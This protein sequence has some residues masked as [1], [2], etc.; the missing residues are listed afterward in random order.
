MNKLSNP[1]CR[2]NAWQSILGGW[3]VALFIWWTMIQILADAPGLVIDSMFVLATALCGGIAALLYRLP[4]GKFWPGFRKEIPYSFLLTIGLFAIIYF[5][6]MFSGLSDL[7]ARSRIGEN[8]CWFLTS[9]CFPG[10]LLARVVIRVWVWWRGVCRRHFVWEL[11]FSILMVIAVVAVLALFMS[12]VYSFQLRPSASP[13]ISAETTFSQLIFWS[14]LLL[15]LMLLSAAIGVLFFLPLAAGFS[16]LVARKLTHR[17]NL[18][19]KAAVRM[20]QG[21]LSARIPVDGQDEVSTLQQSFNHMAEG[22]QAKTSALETEKEKV[23]DLLQSQQELTVGI[24]HELRT[25]VASILGYLNSLQQ[26]WKKRPAEDV[27]HDL[28]IMKHEADRMKTILNDLLALSQSEMERLSLNLHPVSVAELVRQVVDTLAPLAWNSGKVEVVTDIDNH[29]LPL[30][31]A[32]PLRVE[33]ILVN[34]IRNGIRHTSP[35]GVVSVG[36]CEEIGWIQ[37][38]VSDT[39]EG[40]APDQIA[41]IWEKFYRAG[42]TYNPVYQDGIGI[43]LTLVKELTEAMSGQVGVHSIPGQGSTFWIKFPEIK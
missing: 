2:F 32:D 16:Y 34:L 42:D 38:E 12:I 25:P 1:F 27:D 3:A 36:V 4:D 28:S 11:T 8:E 5:T 6:L 24:S 9:L 20:E 18:L 17:I 31:T 14:V 35:G 23:T 13:F 10:F 21:Q 37:I 22:L 26:D 40:I 39:G 41:H 15:V 30:I 19:T 7:P 29:P 33:Q 43:G